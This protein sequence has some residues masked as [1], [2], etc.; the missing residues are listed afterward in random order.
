MDV[1]VKTF[2]GYVVADER[3]ALNTAKKLVLELIE[4]GIDDGSNWASWFN[5]NECYHVVRKLDGEW[6]H[7]HEVKIWKYDKIEL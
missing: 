7:T 3:E 6:Y 1:Q 2:R 4:D 5:S